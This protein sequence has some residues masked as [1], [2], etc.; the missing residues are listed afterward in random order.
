VVAV[1]GQIHN[2]NKRKQININKQHNH[3]VS[4]T[5]RRERRTKRNFRIPA[6]ERIRTVTELPKRPNVQILTISNVRSDILEAIDELATRQDR[7]RS[8]FVR[9]ELERIVAE[10]KAKEVLSKPR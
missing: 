1:A 9:R 10:Y 7:S 2:L 3:N 8:S 6:G 4:D 5:S